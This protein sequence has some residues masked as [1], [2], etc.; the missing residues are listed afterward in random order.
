MPGKTGQEQEQ[1][2]I[3]AGY[4]TLGHH[5]EPRIGIDS[6]GRPDSPA[7]GQ[8]HGHQ[9][10]EGDRAE[11]TGLT[12]DLPI[13]VM[14]LVMKP[15]QD[16]PRDIEPCRLGSSRFQRPSRGTL[17]KPSRPTLKP[18]CSNRVCAELRRGLR[19]NTRVPDRPEPVLA[20]FWHH[21]PNAEEDDEG[22]HQ[23]PHLPE[24]CTTSALARKKK[25]MVFS[26][27]L[28]LFVKTTDTKAMS[29]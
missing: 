3:A 24:Q 10:N 8:D 5:L 26:I 25:R 29:R 19:S 18:S 7:V 16:L 15:P 6:G 12:H 4:A 17:S 14:S 1:D 27:P 28:R 22:D 23:L 13:Q 9:Q 11:D 21:D 20:R 2:R